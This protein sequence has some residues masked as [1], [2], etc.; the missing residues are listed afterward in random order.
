[1]DR[2]IIALVWVGGVVLMAAVY[3]IGP[4]QFLA[5]CEAISMAAAR[6]FDDLIATL[7]W[8]TFEA[9]RAAAIALYAVFVVLAVLACNAVCAWAECWW[10]SPSYSRCWFARTGTIRAPNGL[11]PRC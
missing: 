11:L 6:F 10:A 3:A 8:R 4:Q 2:R 7:M 9:M 5:S 1:M